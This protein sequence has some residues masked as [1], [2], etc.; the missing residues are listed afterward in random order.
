MKKYISTKEKQKI[1]IKNLQ[2]KNDE[3]V[4]MRNE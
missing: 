3:G 2:M 1:K 4:K